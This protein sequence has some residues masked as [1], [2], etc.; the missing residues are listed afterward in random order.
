MSKFRVGDL[1]VHFRSLNSRM[2]KLERGVIVD[3]KE[4][5]DLSRCNKETQYKLYTVGGDS[6]WVLGNQLTLLESEVK[7]YEG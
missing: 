5:W 6:M 2:H 7:K 4:A 3:E 1:V